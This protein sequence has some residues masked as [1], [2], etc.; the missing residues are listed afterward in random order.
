MQVDLIGFFNPAE[1]MGPLLSLSVILLSGL[2]GGALARRAGVPAITGNMLAG[3]CIGPAALNLFSDTP[4]ASTLQPLS[5]F[6]MGLIAVFVGSHLSYRLIHNALRRIVLIAIFEAVGAV[7]L[8]TLAIRYL[9]SPWPVCLVLGCISASTAPATT[10]A[11]IREMR[12]KGPFVKTLVSVVAIDNM[13][14]IVLFAFSTSLLAA[15]YGPENSSLGLSSAA[16]RTL[17]QFCGAIMLGSALG[18]T[19]ERLVQRA[20]IHD[21]SAVFVAILVSVG[22]SSYLALSPLLTSLFFGVYLGNSS[23]EAARQSKALEPLELLL[24]SCFF[25]VAGA[26]VHLHTLREAGIFTLA[27]LVAR[28]VG[29]V[30]GAALGGILSGSS[31]RIYGNMGLAVIPQAGVA[32]GLIVLLSGDTHIPPDVSE[33]IST[34]VLGAVTVNEL[35]GPLFTRQTLVRVNEVNKDKRRLIEFLQ[36][37][38]IL[39]G[40][41][42]QDKWEA[43]RKLT[44]FYSRTHGV[45][46]NQRESLYATV[47]E[48]EEELTTAIG[49]GAAIPHGR[50]PH[51][52]RVQ[53]VL[54]LSRNGVDFEALDGAPVHLMMLVVTPEGREKEHLEVMASLASMISNEAIRTRLIAA[55]NAYDAWEIIEG[56]ESR[57]YNYFLEEVQDAVG[58]G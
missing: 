46:A 53:G 2:A 13:L 58:E 52:A 7:V 10:I 35:V 15:Y 44:D 48:R 40:L 55:L 1:E 43:V 34:L 38:F 56:E 36:E 28:V 12:A 23:E 22:L 4:I 50:V 14:C 8:V 37:E 30:F 29:K 33:F 25:T 45:P 19:T 47:K 57:D 16:V 32:I 18:L 17:W 3:V 24:F 39:V 31:S 54:A 5:T 21:F 27:F 42:A 26:S 11:V 9:G 6:A 20:H 51:G 49:K 41:E